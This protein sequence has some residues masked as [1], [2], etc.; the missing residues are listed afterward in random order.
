MNIE[1]MPEEIV[2]SRDSI[3]KAVNSPIEI[4]LPLS[5][6]I[7]N[8]LIILQALSKGKVQIEKLS[9]AEDTILLSEALKQSQGEVNIG[10]A[11]TAMRFLTA[12]YAAN[13]DADVVLTGS[14]RM[15]QRPIKT[16]VDALKKLDADIN[17][18]GNEGFPP[19]KIKGKQLK[20]GTL[21]IDSGVSSQYI[22]ALMMIASQFD[23]GLKIELQGDTVSMPYITMTQKLMQHCGIEVNINQ[24]VI[25]VSKGNFIQINMAVEADWSAAAFWFG[26][27]ILSETK[28]MLNG[29]QSES[30]Q[31]DAWLSEWF[32]QQGMKLEFS[33]NGLLI[34]PFA[35]KLTEDII[36]L[37]LTE[38]PDL[39]QMYCVLFSALRKKFSITGLQTLPIK[40]SN[41]IEALRT[42]L[43]KFKVQFQPYSSDSISGDATHADFSLHQSIATYQDHRMAMSFALLVFVCNKITIQQPEV[44]VKSYPGFWKDLEKLGV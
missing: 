7:A 36:H 18:L 11:G 41:R 32:Q 40:E 33:K 1:N 21:Q 22:S 24:K 5:K 26:I 25:S 10:H 15:L 38:Y 34:D 16:L 20:G 27:S 42:E 4:N 29:L 14:G 19:L 2:L 6:S 44:V 35:F 43:S 23:D 9:D 3:V 39:A 17:Y 37:N 12:Y 13:P 8:R 30:L 28:L 31:G